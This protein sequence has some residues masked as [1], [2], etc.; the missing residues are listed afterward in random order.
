MNH[1]TFTR[2]PGDKALSPEECRALPSVTLRHAF[3]GIG[4]TLPHTTAA[5]CALDTGLLVFMESAETP[6]KAVCDT[7]GG[8]VHLDSC[9]EFFVTFDQPSGLEYLNFEINALGCLHLA[10]GPDRYTRERAEPEDPR[11]FFDITTMIYPEGWWVRYVI[12][13]DFAR[14]YYPGFQTVDTARIAANFYKCG[15]ETA[16]PHLGCWNPIVV[17]KPDFHR[18]DFFGTLGL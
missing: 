17:E 12:P 6:P 16:S 3:E 14:M 5:V 10:F 7:P 9:M 18:P 13:Y 4:N 2:R 11:R 15:D 1:Y 8:K